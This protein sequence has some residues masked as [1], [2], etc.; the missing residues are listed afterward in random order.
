MNIGIVQGQLVSIDCDALIVGLFQDTP[1]VDSVLSLDQ[2]LSGA[3]QNLLA[4]QD[5]EGRTGQTSLVYTAGQPKRLLLVGLGKKDE[6]DLEALRR[7][8]AYSVNK[9]KTHQH[10]VFYYDDI[11]YLEGAAQAVAETVQLVVYEYQGQKAKPK[12]EKVVEH[13]D[14]LTASAPVSIE[15]SVKNG[16][17]I[18][19][20]VTTARDLV[21]LPANICTPAYMAETALTIARNSGLRCE[22]LEEGK[23]RA[24]KMGALLSVSQ[25]S[26]TP[27]RFII[28]E[29]NHDKAKEL[30]TIVLVG[31]GVTFD[32]GGYTIK[33]KEG[34]ATMKGDMAGGAAVIATLK[35]VAELNVP[36]HVVGLIPSADNMISGKA[37][38][39]QDV[40]TA[41]NGVTIEIVSTDAEGRMLLAD[42]LVYASRY[43]PDA[44]VD[45]AT[46]TGGCFIALGGVA[47]GL[48]T[49][50]ETI[51]TR[52]IQAGEQT[53]ERVWH[54]PMF[55]EYRKS[56][57]SETADTKN[58]GSRAASASV[59]A[60]FLQNFVD[61][62][63][64]H[65]DMAG[66]EAGLSD[67]PYVPK[68]ASGY[69]VRLLTEFV[70]LWAGAK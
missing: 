40:F 58:S 20:A 47:A 65:V 42:A 1:L 2:T 21:N 69:G 12:N 67:V 15:A 37:Y 55:K 61:F 30:P 3:I 34:M 28:L 66:I 24:L 50:D 56:L 64:A 17:T 31:K 18:G 54:L 6:F 70:R 22:I 53:F 7:A 9:V 32:T 46:L 41:S 49:S 5:F 39:P 62:P 59:A 13:F 52:L 35:A 27:P 68:T 26:D 11:G 14:L 10:I 45:I 29:H 60:M 48:F 19:T 43:K 4:T 23:M 16:V 36:V 57:E 51:K 25:G 38:R 44:V 8:V 63:W 33:T